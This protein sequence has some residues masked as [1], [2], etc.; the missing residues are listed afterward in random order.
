MLLFR[1]ILRRIE[2]P[3]HLLSYSNSLKK[4]IW[5]MHATWIKKQGTCMEYERKTVDHEKE[6]V[7]IY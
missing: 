6:S 7:R 3:L 5:Y 1:Q 2:N 4:N